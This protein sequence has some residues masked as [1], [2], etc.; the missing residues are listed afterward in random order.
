MK[1]LRICFVGDSFVNGTGD[2]ACL[3]W[4][5]RICAAAQ[6]N[7]H[8][9]TYYNLG[10]RRQT[11][12]EIARRWQAEV[13]ERLPAD[14][15]GRLVFSFGVNDTVYEDGQPRVALQES[16]RH[17]REILQLA[18]TLR[19][20]LMVGPPPMPDDEQN[21]RIAWLSHQFALLCH[22]LTIPYLDVFAP[23][24]Q[25]KDWNAEALAND[26]AHPRAGG[27]SALAR[28]VQDW[29]AWQAWFD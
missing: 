22:E 7:G 29:P 12:H 8:E 4:A 23:L 11:S 21:Q 5:G 28:L 26:G 15:D 3:G 13:L 20:T 6:Q 17:A 2:P 1:H 18:R 25:V 9:V 16:L 24:L 14:C 19:P 10:I 27:Y